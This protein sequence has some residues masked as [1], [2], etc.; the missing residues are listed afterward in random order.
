MLFEATLPLVAASGVAAV[1]AGLW[2]LRSQERWLLV[3]A[4]AFGLIAVSL[5]LADRLVVTDREQL[6]TLLYSLA[7]AA[8]QQDL[9]T[10]LA[11]IDPAA[12]ELRDEA[13]RIV[14]RYRP[15]EVR[16]TKLFVDVDS[17]ASR[18][19]ASA[20]LIVRATGRI[21][22]QASEASSLVGGTVELRKQTDSSDRWL[23]KSFAFR[24]LFEGGLGRR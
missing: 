20:D 11:A 7:A 13:E 12:G 10:I 4:G 5:H 3:A 14:T 19:T 6:T 18:G 1:A 8:E 16:I 23:V 9:P 24:R 15:S 21:G 2:W 22:D 17:S